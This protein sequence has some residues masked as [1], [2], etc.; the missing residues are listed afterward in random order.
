M[1]THTVPTRQHC[2]GRDSESSVVAD[3]I[4]TIESTKRSRLPKKNRLETLFDCC[5]LTVLC[6]EAAIR[7]LATVGRSENVPGAPVTY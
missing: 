6:R 3:V 2:C 1:W 4:Q 7:W 5:S